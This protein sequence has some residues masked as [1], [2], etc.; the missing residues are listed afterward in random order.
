MTWNMNNPKRR[1][2]LDWQKDLQAL[3]GK[4]DVS[5]DDLIHRMEQVVLSKDPQRMSYAD[6][7]ASAECAS[8]PY[9]PNDPTET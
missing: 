4:V 3:A 6:A 5:K 1:C 2:W 9:N 8:G 7:Y